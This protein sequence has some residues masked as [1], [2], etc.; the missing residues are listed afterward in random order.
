MPRRTAAQRAETRRLLL[1]TLIAGQHPT[2]VVRQVAQ[3]FK[4][5]EREVWK[6]Y[7]AVRQQLREAG[8]EHKNVEVTA[9]HFNMAIRQRD[10]LYRRLLAANEL[11][12]C[13]SVLQD[14]DQLL[15]LYPTGKVERKGPGDVPMLRIID[16]RKEPAQLPCG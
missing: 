12:N 14:R 5:T 9:E 11:A 2:A 4:I 16:S 3:R 1:D 13:L 8:L 15:D 6:D 7:A 10:D